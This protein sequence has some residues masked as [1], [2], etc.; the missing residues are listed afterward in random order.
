[1]LRAQLQLAAL[2]STSLAHLRP[3][4]AGGVQILPQHHVQPSWSRGA[5]QIRQRANHDLRLTHLHG[6]AR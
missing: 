4:A 2:H 3:Q 5:G 1:M 6:P